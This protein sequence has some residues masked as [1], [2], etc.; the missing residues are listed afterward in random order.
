MTVRPDLGGDMAKKVLLGGGTGSHAEGPFGWA[1]SASPPR[2]LET[3]PEKAADDLVRLVL[4][5]VETVRQ[6]VERQAIRRVESGSLSEDEVE[7]LGV[8]LLRLEERMG[9]LKAQFGIEEDGLSLHLGTAR[10]LMDV[11]TEEDAGRTGR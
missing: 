10:E 9:E 5:L 11:L 4:A 3:G 6:L 2:R 7:R 1:E 8:T